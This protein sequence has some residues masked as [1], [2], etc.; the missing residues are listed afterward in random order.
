VLLSCAD[1]EVDAV[2]RWLVRFRDH[3]DECDEQVEL[4]KME[5]ER[6]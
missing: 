4:W 1:D 5:A 2:Y 3:R 6:G